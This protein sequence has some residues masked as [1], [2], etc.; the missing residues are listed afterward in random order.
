MRGQEFTLL[1]W[2]MWAVCLDVPAELLESEEISPTSA[3]HR[4]TFLLPST[5][6][7]QP[8]LLYGNLKKNVSCLYC[9][10]HKKG[11]GNGPLEQSPPLP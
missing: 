11:K 4:N 9:Q 6:S 2:W 3:H 1:A 5:S 7:L 10:H 8:M